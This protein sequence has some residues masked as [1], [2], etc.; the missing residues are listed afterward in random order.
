[1][2]SPMV[3]SNFQ[4]TI[5]DLSKNVRIST[6]SALQLWPKEYAS[7]CEKERGTYRTH[8][9]M[10]YE[11]V[12]AV[13]EVAEGANA[14]SK[15]LI[16]GYIE[17]GT[18]KTFMYEMAFTWEM[19]TF[20]EA[21]PRLLNMAGQY[22]ARSGMLTTEYQVANLLTN[23][24][25]GTGSGDGQPY[26][27][28]SH[29]FKAGNDYSNLLTAADL[30][31]TSLQTAIQA[32]QTQVMEYDIPAAL[33]IKQIV[34]G[35]QNIFTLPEL[36]K[37]SLDPESANN[38]YNVFREYGIG[39]MLS[40]YIGDADAWFVDTNINTRTLFD[41]TGIKMWSKVK[42]NNTLSEFIG[43]MLGTMFHHQYA[44][45]GNQGA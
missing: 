36:L 21:N 41:A 37:S 14:D 39:K 23:G 3:T 40:H 2:P 19:Q 17:S 25:T 35:T 6:I 34:I 38:T 12:G 24:F 1:M 44:S 13:P 11:G 9:D 45:F 22:Q 15:Q 30:D 31:K 18:H 33:Q 8:K 5:T 32:T 42:D 28:A 16:E 26:F 29:V 7:L 4:Q 20:S 43:L 10:G 27:S